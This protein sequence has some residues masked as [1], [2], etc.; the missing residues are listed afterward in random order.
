MLSVTGAIIGVA[1]SCATVGLLRLYSTLQPVLVWQVLVLAPVVA[2]VV[3]IVFGTAPALKAA[4]KDPID[5]LRH[6]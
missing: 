3:G 2:V 4:R 5:A 6:E 1:L